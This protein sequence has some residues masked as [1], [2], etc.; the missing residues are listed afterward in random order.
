M[1]CSHTGLSKPECSCPPCIDELVQ[2]HA[3]RDHN[4][5]LLTPDESM[6]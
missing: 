1:T 3:H 4:G 6:S 5:E 2:K